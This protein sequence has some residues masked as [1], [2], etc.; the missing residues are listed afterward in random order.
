MP[1][2]NPAPSVRMRAH[3]TPTPNMQSTTTKKRQP[4][5]MKTLEQDTKRPT[6]I[7]WPQQVKLPDNI[8]KYAV[9]DA[10]ELTRLGWTEFVRQRWGRGDF[11]SMSEVEHLERRLLRQYKHRGAPVMMM[12]G[13]WMEGEC[14]A[15]LKRGLQKSST[16][17]APFLCKEF[18]LMVETGQWTVLPHSVAKRLPGL[19]LS[20]PGVKVER[21]RRPLWLG[22]YSYFKTSTETLPVACLSSMQYGCTLDRLLHEIVFAYPA[23]GL[24]YM[25]KA[26]VLDGFY[27]KW[28]R[29]EDATKIGLILPSGADEEPM[30]ATPLTLPMGWNPPPFIM[31]GHRN[32]SGSFK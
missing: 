26:D 2:T 19:R 14:L 20:P 23:L 18:A 22:N 6:R 3:T 8:S 9:R 31:C 5:W 4:K 1:T 13:E 11:D 12:T 32:S 27:H 21:D 15:A 24:V 10:E 30:V 17:H 7:P 29:P 28:I 25:P 16:E